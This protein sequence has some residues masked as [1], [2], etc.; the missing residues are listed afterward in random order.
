MRGARTTLGDCLCM[1]G[2]TAVR[3]SSCVMRGA[4][5]GVCRC[6]EGGRT[7]PEAPTCAGSQRVQ[8]TVGTCYPSTTSCTTS[9]VA[10]YSTSA[11]SFVVLHAPGWRC[12]QGG[13]EASGGEPYAVA[14]EGCGTWVEWPGGRALQGHARGVQEGRATCQLP[15]AVTEDGGT[16][17]V[18]YR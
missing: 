1:H 10:W 6:G 16:R 5:W 9:C 11:L 13:D 18:G 3:D 14:D 17:G 12:T 8:H 7:R 15:Y 2:G 4:G